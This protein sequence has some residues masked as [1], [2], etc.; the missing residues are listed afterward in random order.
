[1]AITETETE[2]NFSTHATWLPS[3]GSLQKTVIFTTES[4]V[5]GQEID[6]CPLLLTPLK[7]SSSPCEI[8][9]KFEGSSCEVSSIYVRSTARI[10]ELYSKSEISADNEYICT[11]RGELAV[12]N[13][14]PTYVGETINKNDSSSFG[15]DNCVD[16]FSETSLHSLIENGTELFLNVENSDKESHNYS[17]QSDSID[18]NTDGALQVLHESIRVSE[19]IGKRDSQSSDEDSWVEVGLS[20][21]LVDSLGKPGEMC[22]LQSKGYL[23]YS[24]DKAA[25]KPELL[26]EQGE[27]ISVDNC[28]EL[29][30][31]E[32]NTSE[33]AAFLHHAKEENLSDTGAS[34]SLIATNMEIKTRADE[35]IASLSTSRMSKAAFYE[36]TVEI[37]N[38]NPC[39]SLTIRLLSLQDKSCVEIDTIYIYGVRASDVKDTAEA[40]SLSNSGLQGSPFGGSLLAMLLPSMLQM[41]RGGLTQYQNDLLYNVRRDESMPQM[42]STETELSRSN[43]SPIISTPFP[44]K[45]IETSTGDNLSS[46]TVPGKE[47]SPEQSLFQEKLSADL[48]KVEENM[49]LTKNNL[50]TTLQ[51][52]LP[53]M[54]PTEDIKGRQNVSGGEDSCMGVMAGTNESISSLMDG[55]HNEESNEHYIPEELESNK[56]DNSLFRQKNEEN[57]L[58]NICKR[59]DRLE[60]VCLRIED[61]IHRSFEKMERRLQLVESCQMQ[62]NHSLVTKIESNTVCS[63]LP[64]VSNSYS[65]NSISGLEMSNNGNRKDIA[66]VDIP[67]LLNAEVPSSICMP[68]ACSVSSPEFSPLFAIASPTTFSPDASCVG[69]SKELHSENADL[70][71]CNEESSKA[72]LDISPKL[73]LDYSASRSLDRQ[74]LSKE[75]HLGDMDSQSAESIGVCGG[76]KV[77]SNPINEHQIT[78]NKTK[79]CLEEVLASELSAFSVSARPAQVETQIILTETPPDSSQIENA[80]DKEGGDHEGLNSF[81]S[82]QVEITGLSTGIP[83][84]SLEVDHSD[85]EEACYHHNTL[86]NALEE[87]RY[88]SQENMYSVPYCSSQGNEDARQTVNRG[89]NISDA[90]DSLALNIKQ[91][92][93]PGTKTVSN[94]EKENVLLED[95]N[96]QKLNVSEMKLA[97]NVSCPIHVNQTTSTNLVYDCLGKLHPLHGYYEFEPFKLCPKLTKLIIEKDKNMVEK[98]YASFNHLSGNTESNVAEVERTITSLEVKQDEGSSGSDSPTESHDKYASRQSNIDTSSLLDVSFT[99]TDASQIKMSL[100]SL[101]GDNVSEHGGETVPLQ[102]TTEA[103][104]SNFSESKR[105]HGLFFVE[106][107][108][109]GEFIIPATSTFLCSVTSG[110]S[111]NQGI[112]PGISPVFES[113]L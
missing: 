104:A 34:N 67:S 30:Q 46:D 42:G 5:E 63:D 18:G 2:M 77:S 75:E 52:A 100:E 103:E 111:S 94:H 110:N 19:E 39:V 113:L 37:V 71:H 41:S 97:E 73:E 84:H 81:H 9:L 95:E 21:S 50:K 62:Q 4:P 74:D 105:P 101:L 112:V 66:E 70:L 14:D 60:A 8:T 40:I 29:G 12:Q 26:A 53:S 3:H 93:K 48:D 25:Q 90:W 58:E 1:M 23:D 36:A 44:V 109:L 20:G 17:S 64:V 72:S 28:I 107:E 31:H 76:S 16:N 11:A 68:R 106:D 6:S 98:K 78:P 91:S 22:Q 27:K 7:E 43:N 35:N 54:G 33:D 51:N 56:I 10:F 59:M 65:E 69:N 82:S 55:L 96:E 102:Q 80:D 86:F 15:R 85:E 24:E 89:R 88:I 57:V 61:Y 32:D 38:A 13:D 108:G 92:C 99:I 47:V 79:L 45:D 87:V 83:C 49:E